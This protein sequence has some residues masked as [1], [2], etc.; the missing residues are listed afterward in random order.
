MIGGCYTEQSIELSVQRTDPSLQLGVK[1]CRADQV[2]TDE[3]CRP[4]GNNEGFIFAGTTATETSVH[5]VIDDDSAQ[6]LLKLFDGTR[7]ECGVI[8]VGDG[9]IR[10]DI[11]VT[12]AS[13]DWTCDGACAPSAGC[14][15]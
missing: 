13:L 12:A 15:Y 9:L 10:Y 6:V 3:E 11:T 7:T 1:V 5:V 8:T 14:V 4:R 2:T